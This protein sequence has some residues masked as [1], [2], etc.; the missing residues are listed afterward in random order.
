MFDIHDQLSPSQLYQAMVS[1]PAPVVLECECGQVAQ[2]D[3]FVHL[4]MEMIE[5]AS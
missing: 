4:K 3:F 2:P 1:R 5:P